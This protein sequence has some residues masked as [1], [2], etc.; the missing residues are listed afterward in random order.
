MRLD[1]HR[2]VR[3]DPARCA[4]AGAPRE[5][6]STL[7]AWVDQGR[8]LIARARSCDDPPGRVP[9]GLPLPPSMGRLRLA[10]AVPPEAI[11]SSAPPPLLAEASAASPA[12][13]RAAIGT[14]VSI[15]SGVRC[16]GGLAWAALTGLPYLSATSDLDLL[17]EVGS[18]RAADRLAAAIAG[19]DAVAPMR[20]DGEL[21]APGRLAVQWR[22]WAS[23]AP[24]LIAKSPDGARL[25]ARGAVFA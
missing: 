4:S 18:A 14:L 10:V 21:V 6:M 17:W 7:A 23:G 11:L 2:I 25:V 5:G 19:V 24:A 16:F 12:S 20:I 13:W 8:P 1:R 15:E 3:I 9:L 22:E